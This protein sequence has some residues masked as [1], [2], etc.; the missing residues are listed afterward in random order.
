MAEE[1]ILVDRKEWLEEKERIEELEARFRELEDKYNAFVASH[2]G[3]LIVS[4]EEYAREQAEIAKLEEA[5]RDAWHRWGFYMWSRRSTLAAGLERA[6]ATYLGLIRR[7]R[8]EIRELQIRIADARAELH[9]KV[10]LPPEIQSLVAE[11]EELRAELQTELE[12]FRRKV[13]GNKLI[14]LHKRWFYESPRR[15]HDISIE[16]IVSM[17]IPSDENKEDYEQMLIDS[18]EDHLFAQPGF[19]RLTELSEE[20]IGFEEKL[21]EEP[22]RPPRVENL[23]WWHAVFFLPQMNI[24]EFMEEA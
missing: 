10:V 7:A 16:G 18:L 19:E 15:G 20:V 21:T 8:Y 13:V 22:V 9:R 12:R 4:P 6:A 24:R 5:L 3:R 23:N 17:V 14:A 11:M 2:P 1:R